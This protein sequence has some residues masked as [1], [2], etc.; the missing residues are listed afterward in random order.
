MIVYTVILGDYDNIKPLEVKNDVNRYVLITDNTD[1]D[2]NGWEVLN[3]NEL[4]PPKGLKGRKLQRWAKIIGGL[5][6]FKEDC[7]YID[8]SIE[9]K[10]D[11]NGFYE[12]LNTQLALKKHPIRKDYI[13]EIEACILLKKDNEDALLKQA[14]K[15]LL[16]GFINTKVGLFETGIMYRK[17][18]DEVLDL[19]REWWDEVDETT[20]RDQV[21]L[22]IVLE[23]KKIEFKPI[24][25]D[26]VMQ[27]FKLWF[28]KFF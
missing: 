19:C 6:Y 23:K 18:N 1:I 21:S 24:D 8:G 14:S 17:Y 25:H 7:L 16:Q 22:P 10:K 3:I 5:L 2:D 11:F 27:Y 9:I 12:G 4:N 28:H 26:I 20:I 15:Y 13:Q